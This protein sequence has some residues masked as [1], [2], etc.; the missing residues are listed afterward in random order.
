MTMKR[1]GQNS[2]SRQ[3]GAFGTIVSDLPYDPS[4][5]DGP[6]YLD[7]DEAAALLRTSRKAI[8]T[9]AERNQLPG[10]RKFRRRLLVRRDV[11][12]RA[13]ESGECA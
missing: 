5:E 12:L 4:R 1:N 9:L 3:S 7:A 10:A 11:L 2:Q 13:I 6:V 8:Y